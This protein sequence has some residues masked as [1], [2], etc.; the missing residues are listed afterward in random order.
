MM[1]S[2][3]FFRFWLDS[4]YSFLLH[5]HRLQIYQGTK[6]RTFVSFA[7]NDANDLSVVSIDLQRFDKRLSN[8]LGGIRVR[9]E[10]FV[11]FEVYCHDPYDQ[12]IPKIYFPEHPSA[13]ALTETDM[14]SSAD[15]FCSVEEDFPGIEEQYSGIYLEAENEMLRLHNRVS[16]SKED[17]KLIRE[18]LE[19]MNDPLVSYNKYFSL[20]SLLEVFI[21]G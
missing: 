17:F 4:T 21:L 10:A 11:D 5:D 7:V 2:S 13:T 12:P 15:Q 18:L 6:T 19:K 3:Q 8:R 9:K 14:E 20:V 1:C 16:L